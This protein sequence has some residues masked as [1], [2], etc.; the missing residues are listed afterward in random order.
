MILIR[1]VSINLY[2]F[3]YM[4]S[5]Q[6]NWK[7]AIVFYF[8]LMLKLD[9]FKWIIQLF[10]FFF[11]LEKRKHKSPKNMFNVRTTG[12]KCMQLSVLFATENKNEFELLTLFYTILCSYFMYARN[13]LIIWMTIEWNGIKTRN[14]YLRNCWK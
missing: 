12:L 4:H 7:R 13:V 11:F 6:V 1:D 5:T 2:S 9:S 3:E 14:G 8:Y 10:F